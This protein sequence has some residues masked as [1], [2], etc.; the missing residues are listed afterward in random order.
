MGRA[1]EPYFGEKALAHPL[2]PANR[3]RRR[4]DR[5]PLTDDLLN[6]ALAKL[7]K[8]VP[9]P[10][11]SERR[12]SLS[13]E[14]YY[15]RGTPR[16]PAQNHLSDHYR[17]MPEWAVDTDN[18]DDDLPPEQDVVHVLGS[19]QFARAP[20]S[21]LTLSRDCVEW[22]REGSRSPTRPPD[23]DLV[24]GC[25]PA[26]APPAWQIRYEDPDIEGCRRVLVLKSDHPLELTN[27]RSRRSSQVSRAPRFDKLDCTCPNYDAVH[28]ADVRDDY[29]TVCGFDVQM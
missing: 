26:R 18:D 1:T 14:P 29:A 28:T 21:L 7:P 11:A 24:Y 10:A 15:I 17:S 2:F 6:N 13:T 12:S 3:R 9:V 23:M 22:A 19:A 5:F 20:R 25:A 27:E 8:A 4:S 16:F